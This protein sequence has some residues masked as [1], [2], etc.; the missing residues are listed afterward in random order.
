MAVS[1]TEAQEIMLAREKG[2]IK[3]ALRPAGDLSI[4]HLEPV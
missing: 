3:I 4:S 1:I 2:V